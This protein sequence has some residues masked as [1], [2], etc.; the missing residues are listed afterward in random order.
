MTLAAGVSVCAL[1]ADVTVADGKPADWVQ[2]V[3]MGAFTGRDGR[4]WIVRD[5]AHAAEIISASAARAGSM[6][7]VIDY[8][9][10]TDFG[11]KPGVGGTAI[12]GGWMKELQA[13]SDGIYAR[14]EWTAAAAEKL[15]GRE[16]RYLSPVIQHTE[17]GTVTRILRAALTNSPNLELA[18]VAAE[19]LQE[20]E[21]VK[22]RETLVG[23][24]GLAATVTDEQIA[25][26]AVTATA[27]L[28]ELTAIRTAAKAKDGD[29]ATAVIIAIQSQAAS[30]EIDPSKYVPI[31]TF[32]AVNAQLAQL[33]GSTATDTAEAAV[34][35]AVEEGK[36]LPAT[37]PWA[38]DYAK[39][40][41]TSFNSY[42]ATLSP[43]IDPAA[44]G[45]GG[46][47]PPEKTAT[48][49]D[50]EKSVCATMGWDE[51]TFL[52]SKMEQA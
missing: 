17:D 50:A 12:A 21:D 9:H 24:L 44:R 45:E 49:S 19:Q 16:Y 11:A 40:D 22:L 20:Q 38:L 32:T 31:E 5:A 1:G 10:Q 36:I 39:K 51:A 6:D 34:N 7:L 13:R 29:D 4:K 3:P 42:V 48:L 30:A 46:K 27:A 35:K 14:V 25:E 52:K 18:A 15:T 26:A 8:D 37:K 43:V 47:T 33:M 2:L 28:S 41:L 23:A